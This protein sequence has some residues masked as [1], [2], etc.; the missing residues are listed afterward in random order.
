VFV[1]LEPDFHPFVIPILQRQADI[2]D[3]V[4]VHRLPTLRLLLSTPGIILTFDL[5]HSLL[6]CMAGHMHRNYLAHVKNRTDL[7]SAS[8]VIEGEECCPTI[9]RANHRLEIS[10]CPCRTQDD[11]EHSSIMHL[12]RYQ[13]MVAWIQSCAACLLSLPI[14]QTSGAWALP[15]DRLRHIQVIYNNRYR[16]SLTSSSI[17]HFSYTLTQ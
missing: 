8:S 1:A 11:S 10:I 17:D 12:L 3:I 15:H 16:M 5:Y 9:P 4:T 7:K 2:I 13:Q 6:L 14:I